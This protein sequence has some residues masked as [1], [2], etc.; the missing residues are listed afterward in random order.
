[1]ERVTFRLTMDTGFFSMVFHLCTAY[2]E[3][4]PNI[5]VDSSRWG[6]GRWSTF[7]RSLSEGHSLNTLTIRT[8][9]PNQEKWSLGKYRQVLHTIL[10]PTAIVR[11]RVKEVI[12]KIG[13]PYTAIFVR[14]GDKIASGEANYIPMSEI[15]KH[16]TYDENTVFFLQTD[17]YTVVE[18]T[19]RLLP[20]HIIHS[21]VPPTKRGSYHHE[22]Y[23]QAVGTPWMS[24][25]P[26][27][28][29]EEA[30]EM[31]TGLFVCLHAQ[32][33]W[34][35]DTSNVGRFLKLYDDR[36]H[37]YPEDYSVNESFCTHPAW[38]LRS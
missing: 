8:I 35:D 12:G 15:L 5:L 9:H 4:G 6:Y 36:I 38:S 7:F 22:K 33:C 18:E 31:L 19:K 27:E 14:R 3:H 25:S 28:A 26:E 21:T 11:H 13:C 1:M 30:L 29:K 10:I 2:L 23:K 24:K 32:Q 37:V 17:D 20:N 34:T 16:V